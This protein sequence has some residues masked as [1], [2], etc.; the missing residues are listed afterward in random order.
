MTTDERIDA[1]LQD[2]SPEDAASG[3]WNVLSRWV[4][5][6]DPEIPASDEMTPQLAEQLLDEAAEVGGITTAAQ[7]ASA[8]RYFTAEN[9]HGLVVPACQRALRLTGS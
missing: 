7:W 8:A 5:G 9:V 6:H 1:M 2:D 3:L 4:F